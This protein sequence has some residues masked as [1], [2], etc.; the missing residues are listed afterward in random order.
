[1][2][3]RALAAG[4]ALSLAATA[5]FA[6]PE[7]YVLDNTHTQIVFHY[8]HL[9]FSTGYG[10]F[11]GFD[12][13]ITFDQEEPTASSVTVSFPITSLITGIDARTEHFLSPDFF[14]KSENKTV[15]F[16]STAI[17]VTGEKTAKITGDLTLNGV[18]KPVVLDAALTKA[19]THPMANKPWA[20][21]T[22]TTVVKRSD[23]D[24]GM[25]VP[26]VGD[27]VTV[28]IS[29]EAMKAE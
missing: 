9:G 6:A 3:L 26:Y 4:L 25:F 17:E 13:E 22:A 5:A 23:F 27:D 24:L 12:G 29:I 14:G 2:T 7:K 1:M 11:A 8:D 21:F 10:M 28:E 18:T 19:D 20:G 15:T 16:T